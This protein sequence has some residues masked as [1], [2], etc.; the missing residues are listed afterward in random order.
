MFL[1]KISLRDPRRGVDLTGV[2]AA[3]A[4]PASCGKHVKLAIPQ[5]VIPALDV[6]GLT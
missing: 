6:L 2:E 4:F 3:T 1:A 5:A